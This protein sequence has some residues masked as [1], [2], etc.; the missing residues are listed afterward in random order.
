MD[1]YTICPACKSVM[2]VPD[3]NKVYTCI[4]CEAH[5]HL[6]HTTDLFKACGIIGTDGVTGVKL[7]ELMVSLQS[8]IAKE[9]SREDP[10]D[11]PIHNL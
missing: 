3:E 4:A 1:I 11:E 10:K 8:T 5:P 6:F 7:M 9:M 2:A